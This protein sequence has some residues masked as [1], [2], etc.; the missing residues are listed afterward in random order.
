PPARPPRRL[1]RAVDPLHPLRPAD[2]RP[3]GLELPLLLGRAA[4]AAVPR[5]DGRAL[6]DLFPQPGVAPDLG[7]RALAAGRGA[8]VGLE[9]LDP[10]Q[11]A[12]PRAR[13]AS[14]R[15]PEPRRGLRLR[16]GIRAAAAPPGV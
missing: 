6:R 10:R 3:G 15:D 4:R 8:G 2:A 11:G 7:R 12:R 16:P 9:A 14:R 5:G 13:G 1:S